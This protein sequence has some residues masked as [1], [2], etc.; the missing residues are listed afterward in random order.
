MISL[1]CLRPVWKTHVPVVWSSYLLRM[2]C[3]LRCVPMSEAWHGIVIYTLVKQLNHSIQTHFSLRSVI[4]RVSCIYSC[5][6][7][8]LSIIS[9]L[10]WMASWDARGAC[11]VSNLHISYLAASMIHTNKIIPLPQQRAV[12][13]LS[14]I[15]LL[16][17]SPILHFHTNRP[18]HT[19]WLTHWTEHTTLLLAWK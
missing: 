15:Y 18:F 19:H 6:L 16:F 13:L 14:F 10:R 1:D 9:S 7:P 17:F 2:V 12:L 5:H 8:V 3:W 4:F 11:I